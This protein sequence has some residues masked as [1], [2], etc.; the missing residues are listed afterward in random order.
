MGDASRARE[1]PNCLTPMEAGEE[2]LMTCPVCQSCSR[3]CPVCGGELW[4]AVEAPEGVIIE[5][6]G[7]PLNRCAMTWICQNADCGL[8]VDVGG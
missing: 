7:L 5:E 3:P 8:R 2:D 1:C 6:G 4:M